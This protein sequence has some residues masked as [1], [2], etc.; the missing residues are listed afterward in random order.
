[1]KISGHIHEVTD[2]VHF[3]PS[4]LSNPKKPLAGT[5]KSAPGLHIHLG[6]I[7]EGLLPAQIPSVSAETISSADGKF[8]LNISDSLLKHLMINKMAYFVVYKKVG[9]FNINGRIL[10]AFEAVYRS[11]AFDITKF[12]GGDV[13]IFFALFDFPT[14][15]GISQDKVNEQVKQ[16]KAQLKDLDKLSAWIKDGFI[17]VSGSGRG[18]DLKFNVHLS[19]ST[20]FNLSHFIVG[21]VTDMDIDLPGWDVLTGIF[22]SKDDIQK[23]VEKG[24]ASMMEEV[25]DNIE[26]ELAA[27]VGKGASQRPELVKDFFKTTA[28]VTFTKL[29]FPIVDHKMSPL[30]PIDTRAIVPNVAVGFPRNI[31]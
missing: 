7:L 30:G 28:S 6:S 2:F 31:G 13:D 29:N 23:E 8:S 19:T 3:A 22:V 4:F 20:S 25:N 11:S 14:V 9:T 27:Q 15:G 18:A 16:T 24:I 5:F 10:P 1:M 17:S 26:K 21:E 12:K